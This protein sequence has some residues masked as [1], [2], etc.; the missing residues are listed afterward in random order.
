MDSSLIKKIIQK[1]K[2]EFKKYYGIIKGKLMK[3]DIET[4]ENTL[5]EI[6]RQKSSVS[7]FGDG[8]LDLIYGKSLKFQ[9]YDEKLSAKLKEIIQIDNEKYLICIP[10]T[11]K[12]VNALDNKGSEWWK[13]NLYNN[14]IK[15]FKLLK[16]NKKY[17][18]SFISRFYMEAKDKSKAKDIVLKWKKV[19][20][21]RE[22]IIIEG[23]YSRLGVGNDLFNNAKSVQRVICPTKNAFE[24]Y[25]EILKFFT[26]NNFKNKLVLIALGPTATVLAYDLYLLGYQS[27]D[28]G[29]IDIE[30]EW[31]LKNATEKIAIS[32]K[33]VNEVNNSVDNIA[34]LDNDYKYESEII[35][36][37]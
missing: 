21:R 10:Y 2:F 26:K 3:I 32:N 4:I 9:D 5:D 37:I 25:E 27:I 31:Y 18:D 33:Y 29:H 36:I 14:R 12:N 17:Y 16:R 19:W 15:W 30:Y 23:L 35:C 24:K 1:L 22:I 34:S 28:I 8:E 7:R 6:V 13:F 20:D 11:L